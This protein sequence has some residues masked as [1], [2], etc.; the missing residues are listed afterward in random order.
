MYPLFL[1]MISHF[2]LWTLRLLLFFRKLEAGGIE[3]ARGA[4]APFGGAALPAF[5]GPHPLFLLVQP[6]STLARL[7]ELLTNSRLTVIGKTLGEDDLEVTEQMPCSCRSGAMFLQS[8]GQV[9]CDPDIPSPA[10]A[11]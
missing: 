4:Q 11:A 1:S 9:I 3:C 2:L 6:L 10:R 7:E 5:G 8:T